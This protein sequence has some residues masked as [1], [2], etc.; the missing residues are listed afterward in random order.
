MLWETL[1]TARDLG[2]M[3]DIASVL[4]RYGFGD[5]VRRMGLSHALEQAGK[6]LRWKDS[7]MVRMEPPERI[8]RAW[9]LLS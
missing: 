3:H 1:K 6:V 4:I 8:R 7:H 9:D 5:M 2:R